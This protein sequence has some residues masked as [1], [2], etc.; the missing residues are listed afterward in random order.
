MLTYPIKIYALMDIY[1]SGL[2]NKRRRKRAIK[3][4]IKNHR[5]ALRVKQSLEKGNGRS[6]SKIVV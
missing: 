6:D 1:I 2:E 5:I 4:G 3:R